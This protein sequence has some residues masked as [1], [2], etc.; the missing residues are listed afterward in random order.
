MK[1]ISLFI[2]MT[3]IFILGVFT[4][5]AFA[6]QEW[7]SDILA[8][9]SRYWNRTITVDGQVQAVTANPVGTTRGIYT[10]LDDSGPN[11]IT[12]RINDL[13]PIGRNYAV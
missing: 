6:D 9:P 3:G 1:R 5:E 10:L 11:P 7:V 4:N 2:L 12:I 13:P 8:N